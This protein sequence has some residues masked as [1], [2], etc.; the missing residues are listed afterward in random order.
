MP[1]SN[2]VNNAPKNLR[3]RLKLAPIQLKE[4]S[5]AEWN[6]ELNRWRGGFKNSVK[7]T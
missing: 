1:G 3:I 4:K 5:S 2:V 6:K 7:S